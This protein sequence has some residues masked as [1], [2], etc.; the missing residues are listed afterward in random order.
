MAVE[1]TVK[2]CVYIAYTCTYIV[3]TCTYVQVV[4]GYHTFYACTTK[5]YFTAASVGASY[6]G[7]KQPWARRQVDLEVRESDWLA[8]ARTSRASDTIKVVLWAG[9]LIKT[10]T[11]TN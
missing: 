6:V 10:S 8:H 4:H 2:T 9:I 7:P 5:L 1:T 3:Q 11:K